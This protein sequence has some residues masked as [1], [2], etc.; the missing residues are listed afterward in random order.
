MLSEDKIEE[1]NISSPLDKEWIGLMQKEI[2]KDITSNEIEE[3]ANRVST[4]VINKE[5]NLDMIK[6][7]PR[8]YGKPLT[9]EKYKEIA[10][11]MKEII[12]KMF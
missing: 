8:S 12:L 1:A 7:R 10:E 4:E 3:V 11:M 6:K 2:L 9:Y 5:G